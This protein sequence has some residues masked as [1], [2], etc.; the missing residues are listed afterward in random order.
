MLL[1]EGLQAVFARHARFGAA[2]REAVRA[3]GLETQC[4]VPEEH[5]DV[6]TG[7]RLP[8]GFDA[9]RSGSSSWS[10]STC[11]SAKGS[12]GSRARCSVSAISATSMICR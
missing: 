4:R 12:A 6:L 9:D 5:S 3:W 1:E 2:T 8:A 11:R 10:D 7:V